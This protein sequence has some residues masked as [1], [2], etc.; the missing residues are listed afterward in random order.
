MD[1]KLNAGHANLLANLKKELHIK[2]HNYLREM[3]ERNKKNRR[4][5]KREETANDE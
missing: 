3:N 4:Y 2:S 5:L 1:I